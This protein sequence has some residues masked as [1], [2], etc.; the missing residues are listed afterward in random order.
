MILEDNSL[1]VLIFGNE[2]ENTGADNPIN[3]AGDTMAYIVMLPF[4]S[5]NVSIKELYNCTEL[6]V[7]GSDGT[8]KINPACFGLNDDLTPN[9]DIED[10]LYSLV[11]S[12]SLRETVLLN[13]AVGINEGNLGLMFRQDIAVAIANKSDEER[14]YIIDYKYVFSTVLGVVVILLLLSF[15]IDVAVRSVKLAFLQLIAPIPI[16]SFVDPKS[17]K[18]GMFKQ[19]YQMCFKTYISLFV[20]LLALYFAI[21]II[22]RLDSMVDVVDGTYVSRLL[23]KIF[24]VIGV[25][26]FVKQL[27]KILEGLGIKLDGDG[28]FTLNPLKKITEGVPG[29]KKMLGLAGAA[30]A[31]GLAGAVN[32]GSRYFDKN[33]WLN[34][35]GKQTVGSTLKGFFRAQ[36]SAIAGATSAAYRGFGKA[37]KDEGFG[38]T[39]SNS[40]GEA[41]FAKLQRED[42]RRKGSTLGGRMAADFA[43]HTGNLN[44]AQRQTLDYAAEEQKYKN[45]VEELKTR[46][47]ATQRQKAERM[48]VLTAKENALSRMDSRISSNKKVKDASDV[49][50]SLKS[51]GKYYAAEGQLNAKGLEARAKIDARKVEIEKAEVAASGKISAN[52]STISAMKANGNYYQKDKDGNIKKDKD[53]NNLL[54]DDAR[55]AEED[56]RRS[57]EELEKMKETHA[58][59]IEAEEAKFESDSTYRYGKDE[60]TEEGKLADEK[61]S[62]EK[63]EAFTHMMENDAEFRELRKV[64]GTDTSYYTTTADGKMKFEK[65]EMFNVKN[66]ISAVEAEYRPLEEAYAE[67]ERKVQDDFENALKEK[68]LDKSSATWKG[69]EADNAARRV[70]SAQPEGWMPTPDVNAYGYTFDPRLQGGFGPF[71]PN[72]P[73]GPHGPHEPHDH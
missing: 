25:L 57:E 22:D 63:N 14:A 29:A 1:S 11:E 51:S 31:A 15:C 41:M 62:Q 60:L 70:K 65:A 26:M 6:T 66:A 61:L 27:P 17:G 72:G 44:A 32:F 48:K 18:D 46:K 59:E 43:R 24:V 36:G 39:F 28:K 67:Q 35:D 40:Y 8:A 49:V 54:T 34:K 52:Q 64:L 45:A 10:S 30:G 7:E 21:Y 38:K 4:F 55:A 56:L 47:E 37:M 19:W 20:R 71:G 3:S 23:V 33:N 58:K 2:E 73:N 68:G 9:P 13:Y 42:L 53:G 5:P 69:N 50:E 16:L 12:D